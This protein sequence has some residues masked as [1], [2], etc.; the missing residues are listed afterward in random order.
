V[1]AATT[2]LLA[3]RRQRAV[4]TDPGATHAVARDGDTITVTRSLGDRTT[5]LVLAFGTDPVDVALTGRWEIAFDGDDP[6][7]GGDGSTTLA[8]ERLRTNAPNA[9]LLDRLA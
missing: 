4:L 8:S 7:W 3:R 2:E 9:V 1:L 6:R 5:M